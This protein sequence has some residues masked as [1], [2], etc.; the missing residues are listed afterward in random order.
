VQPTIDKLRP[1]EPLVM[2]FN[3]FDCG[4]ILH[5]NLVPHEYELDD[6]QVRTPTDIIGQHIHL[7]KWDLTTGDGAANGW[8]YEDGALAPGIVRERIHAIDLFNSLAIDAQ[9]CLD[10]PKAEVCIA[11][12]LIALAE[13]PPR[14]VLPAGA[15]PGQL[16]PIDLTDLLPVPTIDTGDPGST[17]VAG[18]TDLTAQPHPFFG[19]GVG[20]DGD[21]YLGA[22]T[23]IQR[24]LMDPVVNVAGVDRGLGLTFSH[25]HYGPSTFQ[26][27]GLYSTILAEPAGSTW[28]HNES[29]VPLNDYMTRVDGGPTTWQAA[30]LPPETALLGS[31]VGAENIPDHREF[32][33]E[34]SDF[35]HAYEAGVYVGADEKGRP[36]GT[37]FVTTVSG[38][39]FDAT[40][41]NVPPALAESWKQ[42]VNPP[43][44]LKSAFPD[45]VTANNGCPGPA[46]NFDPNVPRPCAEAINIG[47][48]SMWVMNYRNEPVGLRVFDPNGDGPDG[49]KDRWACRRPRIRL[50]EPRRPGHLPAEHQLW[51]RA[52]PGGVILRWWQGRRHQLR[53][54]PGRPLHSDYARLRARSGEGQDPDR[55]HRGAAPGHGTWR[56]VAV[57]Q[58]RFRPLGQLRLAGLPVPRHLRAVQPTDA[59]QPRSG[60][61]R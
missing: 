48:S 51:R 1:P 17:V 55:R 18:M 46:G 12:D 49:K 39:E 27:I 22:R 20:E 13:V 36:I 33:F 60:A 14:A 54:Q 23:V 19:A 50:P 21:E 34:M 59:D 8:N 56:E 61:G 45:V 6:F 44:K 10:N 3:T 11:F 41:A 42:T 30:I 15:L 16:G 57:Q 31:T 43:L 58:L 52:V 5:T 38:S 26:Q 40:K 2:R 25:D 28:L 53:S 37:D 47:H 32:Y 9:T 24:I 7:P 35:Q 4:K 29:G